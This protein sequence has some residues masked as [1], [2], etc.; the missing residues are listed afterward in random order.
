MIA[1]RWLLSLAVALP[2]IA[3]CSKEGPGGGLIVV[4]RTD[5][6]LHPPPNTLDV[7]VGPT[8]GG[9]PFGTDNDVAIDTPGAVFSLPVNFAID[10]N[11]DPNASVSIVVSVSRSGTPLETRRYVVDAVPTDRVVELDVV[12]SAEC[13]PSRSGDGGTPAQCCPGA[14]T[15]AGGTC[16]CYGDELPS[17]A[18]DAGDSEPMLVEDSGTAD[19]TVDGTEEEGGARSDAGDAR[20]AND[21]GDADDSH[22]ATDGAEASDGSAASDATETGPCEGGAVQ[23]EDI[24]TPELCGSN[25]KWT[26]QPACNAGSTYCFQGSCIPAPPSCAGTDYT[27][28]ESFE[29]PGGTFLRGEDSLHDDAGARATISGFRLDAFETPISRFRPFFAAVLVGTGLPPYAGAGVHGYLSG[30][31][32]LNGGGDAGTSETGWD[33]SWNAVFPTEAEDWTTMLQS[34]FAHTWGPTQDDNDGLPINCVTWYEAYAFCIWDGGFL[35]SEA[36]WNYAA[37]G[38]GD[39]R[40]YPWGSADPA[41]GSYAIYGCLY[42]TPTPCTDA[43][44][45]SLADFGYDDGRGA[46]GQWNLAGNVA[47]WTLDFYDSYPV[48]CEDCA[49]LSP[50]TQRV[51]R[52]G[53][54]DQG[55]E[56]LYTSTRVPG[57]PAERFNDVGIRCA[58]AP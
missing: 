37:A 26:S 33:P 29:V 10:S 43:N 27:E 7:E 49:A 18:A 22:D 48:P 25:G 31:A 20:E 12:F 8:D 11:G 24:T 28:C 47:E 14:C 51:F 46:F 56:G 23:C 50:A 21:A 5:G 38:G 13:A 55:E 41:S 30:G 3:G 36:E 17:Y 34:C 1:R 39:Q 40:L 54:F 44:S 35:P 2:G 32:G 6:T 4:L 9:P 57:D 19:A 45:A 52:G 15:P 16:E 53:G 58:R 42:P